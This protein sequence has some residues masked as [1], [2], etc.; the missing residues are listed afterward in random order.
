[1]SVEILISV[2]STNEHYELYNHL[3]TSSARS[4]ADVS[5]VSAMVLIHCTQLECTAI[6][7]VEGQ[8]LCAGTMCEFGLGRMF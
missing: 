6:F 7:G 5:G 1:M 2:C 3:C 8:S 4:I